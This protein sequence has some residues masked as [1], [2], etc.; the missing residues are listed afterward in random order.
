[1]IVGHEVT[2][3]IPRVFIFSFHMPLFFILSGYTSDYVDTWIKFGNKAKKQ[4][5]KMWLLA[6]LMVV[7]L[8]LE[9][10]F[11]FSKMLEADIQGIFWGSNVPWMRVQTVAIM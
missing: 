5:I 6:S 11:S 4:F 10:I 9:G 8:G 7:L 2:N 1:M 3:N